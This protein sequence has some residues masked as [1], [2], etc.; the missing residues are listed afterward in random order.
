MNQSKKDIPHD[1][2]DE[3]EQANVNEKYYWSFHFT[4]MIPLADFFH[5]KIVQS[6]VNN[7]LY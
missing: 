4:R 7:S 3:F 1:W 2:Y 6:L 5:L